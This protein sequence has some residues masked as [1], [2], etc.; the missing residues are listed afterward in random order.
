MKW[1]EC[2]IENESS[3]FKFLL[4]GRAAASMLHADELF[5][6][7]KLIPLR[8]PAPS[9]EDEAV[10]AAAVGAMTVQSTWPLKHTRAGA[11]VGGCAATGDASD[12]GG[13]GSGGSQW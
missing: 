10:A 6:G 12:G 13:E 4:G 5:S 2:Q 11:G 7:G 9:A 3:D 1:T 8:I